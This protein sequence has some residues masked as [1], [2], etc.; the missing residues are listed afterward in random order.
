MQIKIQNA[1]DLIS[2]ERNR[3]WNYFKFNENITQKVKSHKRA[4]K[5]GFE[6]A[7]YPQLL[8]NTYVQFWQKDTDS[9]DTQVLGG[10]LESYGVNPSW[11]HL[12][13]A[14]D[15]Q[16]ATELVQAAIARIER[17]VR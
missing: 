8:V 10:M 15:F 16:A 6:S 5:R 3:W 12:R 7:D 9:V 1:W 4:K 11:L 2:N 17:H 13:S 14:A